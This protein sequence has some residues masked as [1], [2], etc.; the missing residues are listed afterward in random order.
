MADRQVK[1]LEKKKAVRPK[2]QWVAELSPVVLLNPKIHLESL[3]AK[4]LATWR[5]L[6]LLASAVSGYS[7]AGLCGY[8]GFLGR[9]RGQQAALL[10]CT[11]SAINGWISIVV[12][13]CTMQMSDI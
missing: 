11:S 13:C 2:E 6:Q 12:R 1:I 9:Q 3:C 8:G 4:I 10:S 5:L 7:S